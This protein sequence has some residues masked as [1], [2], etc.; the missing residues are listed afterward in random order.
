MPEVTEN[1]K[2]TWH[3]NVQNCKYQQ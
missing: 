2:S 1:Q 3:L